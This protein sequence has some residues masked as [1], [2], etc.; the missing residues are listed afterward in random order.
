MYFSYLKLVEL[1]DL[2][3]LVGTEWLLLFGSYL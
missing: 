2:V 3:D 1:V